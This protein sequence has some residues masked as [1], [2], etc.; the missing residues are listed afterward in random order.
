MNI[1]FVI[2][3]GAGALELSAT[4]IIGILII[5]MIGMMALIA[6]GMYWEKGDAL[7][8]VVWFG[9][10]GA[11]AFGIVLVTGMRLP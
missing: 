9:V 1:A 8:S 5:G 11:A 7:T 4:L 10:F 3:S 6:A 2:L